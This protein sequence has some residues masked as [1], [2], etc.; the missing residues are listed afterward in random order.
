[1]SGSP[2]I[3]AT[4]SHNGLP[5]L[6]LKKAIKG[7]VVETGVQ[8]FPG[9]GEVA[10]CSAVRG[11]FGQARSNYPTLATLYRAGMTNVVLHCL[12]KKR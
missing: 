5:V 11:G 12:F 3:D 10:H 8:E 9:I 1:M 7:K 2:I 4:G 6:R